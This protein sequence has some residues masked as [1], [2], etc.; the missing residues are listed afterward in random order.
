[1][2]TI[3]ILSGLCLIA[4]GFAYHFYKASRETFVRNLDLETEES[5]LKQSIAVKK[6]EIENLSATIQG[7]NNVLSSLMKTSENLR[8]GAQEQA[9]QEY[10]SR[11]SALS[12]EYEAKLS[13]LD[14]EYNLK[15]T[16]YQAKEKAEQAKIDDLKAKQ[17]A[18][19]QAKQREA[20]LE[21]Q[22]DYYR[23]V[24][25]DADLQ[26]IESLRALQRSLYRKDVIDKMIWEA[27]IK[28]L[29]DTLM[30]HLFESTAK[31]SG[32]YKITDLITGQVYIGQSVDMR[33]RMRQHIKAALS[34]APAT[35]KLYQAMKKDGIENF[36]FE[37][38]EKISKDKL[39]E[40]EVYYIDLYKSKEVGLNRTVGGA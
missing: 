21:A 2:I 7:Q 35:N 39:N 13:S 25:T 24:L 37:V 32:I 5:S 30:S 27:Y 29:Y 9:Q 28:S 36:T 1:M 16:N 8:A 10:E 6:Q 15:L 12:K 17:L 4:I 19:I 38:L 3:I 22:K 26:D 23:L 18:Y 20:E 31:I 40:R 33:E 14:N 34:S 11:V